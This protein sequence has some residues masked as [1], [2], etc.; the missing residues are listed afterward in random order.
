[1]QRSQN[2]NHGQGKYHRKNTDPEFL[3]AIQSFSE[4]FKGKIKVLIAEPSI[5]MINYK[6]H[7]S[8][9]DLIADCKEY[10]YESDYK[11]F[12]SSIGRMM[13]AYSREKLCEYAVDMGFDYVFFIDDD[14]K[15]DKNIFR[16]LQQ[17]IKEYD[18][19][20]PLCLQRLYPYYPVIY[21]S[22]IIEEGGKKYWNNRKYVNVREFKKGDIITDADS[23][24]F[25]MA[26]IKVSLFEKVDQPWF[27]SMTPVGEDILFCRNATTA[28]A[29]ILVDTRVEAPHL[30]ES[31]FATWEDYVREKNK[32]GDAELSKSGDAKSV[33]EI[34]SI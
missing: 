6:S 3:E 15:Y 26:I 16:H 20:A 24:G 28:G 8:M 10:E 18:I 11:F 13:I 21:K 23:I 25:G 34:V 2:T 1:M 29:K 5:G 33:S 17:H 27:F 7:E 14:H 12:K 32:L 30:K 19:V 31:E 22:E 4:E 9:C